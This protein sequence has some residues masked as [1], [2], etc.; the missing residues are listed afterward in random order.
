VLPSIDPIFGS[1]IPRR[2][3]NSTFQLCPKDLP[4]ALWQAEAAED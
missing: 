3:R 4:A 1:G 2:V